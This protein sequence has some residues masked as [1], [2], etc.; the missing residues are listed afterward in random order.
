MSEMTDDSSPPARI[1]VVEDDPDMRRLIVDYLQDND[2]R[3]VPAGGWREMTTEFTVRE[4]S[5]VLL[6]LNMPKKSGMEVLKW[7][8]NELSIRTLPVIIL[9]S[10]LQ[11]EDIHPAYSAGANAYLGKPS[12]PDDLVHLANAIKD[13]WINHNRTI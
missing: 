13:F 11:D 3:A 7:I 4:P 5:L 6:D 10:S 1:V 12:R 9:T 8:H 2:L